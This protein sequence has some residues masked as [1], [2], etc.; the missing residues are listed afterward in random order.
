MRE[1]GSYTE[2]TLSARA[3]EDP[4]SDISSRACAIE[5]ASTADRVTQQRAGLYVYN[6]ELRFARTTDFDSLLL[7][8]QLE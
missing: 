2:R 8:S 1:G 4:L 7:T 3:A 5:V 6:R